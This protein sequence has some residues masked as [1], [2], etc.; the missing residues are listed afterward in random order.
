MKIEAIVL[1]NFKC[2]GATTI[3][4]VFFSGRGNFLGLIGENGVGK[5]AVL[6]GFDAFFNNKNWHRNKITRSAQEDCGVALIV[7]CLLGEI[8]G[9]SQGCKDA[10]S[11]H[12]NSLRSVLQ[13][14]TPDF[15]GGVNNDLVFFSCFILK[16]GSFGVFDGLKL[17]SDSVKPAC[18]MHKFI[19]GCL[20]YVYV[21]AEVNIDGAVGVN[22]QLL[23][24]IKGT[25]FVGDVE[26]RLKNAKDENGNTLSSQINTL[27]L[28]YFDETVVKKLQQ[29]DSSYSY[30]NITTG[31]SANLSEKQLA[32]LVV[33]VMF[34]NREL[35][36]QYAGRH[37]GLSEMSSGQRRAALLDYL[38]V[39][40]S[41][42]DSIQKTKIILGIDEPEISVGASARI[43][44]FEKLAKISSEIGGVLFSTHWYGWIQQLV[45]GAGLLVEESVDGTRNLTPF[46]L[47]SFS[48]INVS[49][50]YEMRMMFDFLSSLGAWA[51][52]NSNMKFIIC[53]GITDFNLINKHF[54][55][56][57]VIF[58][59]GAGQVINL[60]KIFQDYVFKVNIN[61]EKLR[62]I[63]F[64]ID[65]D[66]DKAK[67]LPAGGSNSNLKR[68]SRDSKGRVEVVC[69]N[70][71]LSEKCSIEDL[72]SAVPFLASLHE[73][74]DQLD[75]ED[76][77]VFIK[78]LSVKYAAETG[79]RSFGLDDVEKMK[80]NSIYRGL[81]KRK[82]SE[83]YSP[84]EQQKEIFRG[85][86]KI[87]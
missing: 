19:L 18:E 76:D 12:N 38:L 44:Q 40:I 11:A 52:N 5:S 33:Q 2:Y 66:P 82:V 78:T 67:D 9:L 25:G 28:N 72:L 4:P 56:Y 60:Y 43:Q 81:F 30:K 21:D 26:K 65:T 58:T 36:K 54:S 14:K 8:A 77:K 41:S 20:T 31:A 22:S 86:F 75:S 50:P 53:E 32:E 80:F 71:N 46:S 3:V 24:F 6:Q 42:L 17:I 61:G 83:I 69:E 23:Q 73:A 45:E 47:K 15:E 48:E 63:V 39:V 57:K 10:I 1:R 49:K 34:K 35:T 59:V 70:K 68:L 55:T 79:A 37:I 16:N 13:T 51:E 64:L 85:L 29:F 74:V 87:F 62:N 27:V 7:S 84:T